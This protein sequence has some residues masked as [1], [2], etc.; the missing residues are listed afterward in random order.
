MQVIV[1]FLTN[2]LAD[3]VGVA[4]ADGEGVGD[5]VALTCCATFTLIIGAE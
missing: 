5:G 2:G 3:G 1:V 4:E